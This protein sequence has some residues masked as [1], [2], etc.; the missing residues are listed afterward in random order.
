M[1]QVDFVGDPPEKLSLALYADSDLAGDRRD[2]KS[3]SGIFLALVGPHTFYPL[4]AVSKKQTA[5]S[6]SSHEAELVSMDHAVKD[7][8]I[9]ALCVWETFL[10]RKRG[11]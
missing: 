10:G 5:T 3:T 6:H 1:R 2:M 11:C 8:G 4:C 7:I 9:P